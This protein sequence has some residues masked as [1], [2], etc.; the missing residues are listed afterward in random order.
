MKSKRLISLF[1][2]FVLAFSS[3]VPA[4]AAR[5]F[6]ITRD[7]KKY[8]TCTLTNKKKSG[9]VTI[10][11]YNQTPFAKN[12]VRFETTRGKHIWSESGAIGFCGQRKFNLGNDNSA[13]RIYVRT[14]SGKGTA[15]FYKPV[16]VRIS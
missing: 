9:S 12:T 14:T 1:L 15:Y 4:F 16:N 13:Y 8:A 6:N 5:E 11:C 10:K 2:V 7:Y 3:I